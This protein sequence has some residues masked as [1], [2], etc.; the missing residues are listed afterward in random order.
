MSFRMHAA[1]V[2]AKRRIFESYL[3][4]GYYIAQAV[5]LLL[6]YFLIS[7]FVSSIDSSGFNYM[8]NPLYEL[9]GRS[10][11]GTFGLTFLKKLFA[12]GPFQ[13]VFYVSIIPVFLYLSLSTVFHFCLEKK[14]GAIELLTYGPVDG[15]SYFLAFFIKDMVLTILYLLLLI[16][17]LSAAALLNNLVLGL[18]F[19]YV[20]VV[21]FFMMMLLYTISIMISVLT[22]S[23]ASAIALYIAVIFLFLIVL[24]GSFTI[25][26]TYIT[27]F[28]SVLSWVINWVSPFFYGGLAISFIEAGYIVNYLLILLVMTVLSCLFLLLSHL[29]IKVKGVHS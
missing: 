24:M 9:I 12:S 29:V 20:L 16:L 14:V 15:T 2:I 25:I 23:S 17:F 13:F 6:S 11:S 4:P 8:L 27:S 21:V 28:S 10:L 1:L 26:S 19:F 22:D 7:G 5:G 3:S 18:A